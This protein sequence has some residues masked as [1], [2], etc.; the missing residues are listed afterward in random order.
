[1]S[2]G[3]A[4]PQWAT[5]ARNVRG[6]TCSLRKSRSQSIRSASVS[7][8]AGVAPTACLVRIVGWVEHLAKPIINLSDRQ[9]GAVSFAKLN[10]SYGIGS[11]TIGKGGR[12]RRQA[13]LHLQ[14]LQ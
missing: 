2:A 7:R 3:A 13:R 1:A 8:F 11:S 6:P 4:P 12:M 14:D 9:A 10:P 5:S